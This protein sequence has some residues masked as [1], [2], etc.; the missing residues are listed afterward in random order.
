MSPKTKV[1]A[2]IVGIN[3]Y[4]TSPLHGCVP[5]AQRMLQYLQSRTDIEL[6]EQVLLDHQGTKDNIV[7]GF[8]THLSQ[9]GPEDTVFFYFSGHGA[10]ERADERIWINEL[11]G[12]LE[13]IACYSADS[14]SLMAD[15]ELRFLIHELASGYNGAPPHILTVFDCCHSGDNTRSAAAQQMENVEEVRERR[16]TNV[17][18]QREWKDFLFADRIQPSDFVRSTFKELFPQGPHV[19]IAAAQDKQ[20]ALEIGGAGVFTSTLLQVLKLSGGQIDYTSLHSLLSNYIRFKHKQI[21]QLASQGAPISLLRAGFLNQAVTYEGELYGDTIYNQKKGW[22]LN[23]GQMHGLTE[24]QSVQVIVSEDQPLS[25]P[26]KVAHPSQ[27]ELDIPFEQSRE[28]D[29]SLFYKTKV[30][31]YE[32]YP[33]YLYI[34]GQ[35][36]LQEGR[37]RLEQE[38]KAINAGIE[39]VPSEAKADYVLHLQNGMAYLTE[40]FDPYRPVLS[41]TSLDEKDWIDR[42]VDRIRQLAQW[43]FALRLHNNKVKL[44]KKPP[45]TIE[46]SQR[47]ADEMVPVSTNTGTYDIGEVN[48]EADTEKY[49][50]YLSIKITNNFKRPLYFCMLLLSEDRTCQLSVDTEEDYGLVEKAVME[51]QPGRSYEVFQHYDP[52]IPFK[53][54]QDALRYNKPV[55][56]SW[57]KFLVSTRDD[58]SYQ[59]LIVPLSRSVVDMPK[60][61]VDDWTTQTIEIKLQNPRYNQ[62]LGQEIQSYLNDPEM[63]PFAA[64]LYLAPQ[65]MSSQLGLKPEISILQPEMDGP[66]RAERNFVWDTIVGAANKW[67]SS[68]RLRAFRKRMERYPQRTL[69]VSEG[70]SWFQHP[71]VTETIDHLSLYYNIYSRG[72]AGDEMRGYMMSGDFINAIEDIKREYPDRSLRFFL[73]SGGGNDI[74][75]EQFQ[76]FVLPYAEVSEEPEGE[77]P[78]RFL[79]P[80]FFDEL[81]AVMALYRMVLSRMRTD[82]S[83][84]HIITHGYD[85]VWPKGVEEKGMSWLGTPMSKAGIVREGDRKAIVDYLID[86]FNSRLAEVVDDYADIATHLDLRGTVKQYQWYDEIHPNSEGYQ[87]IALKYVQLIDSKLQERK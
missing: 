10:Q 73:I 49:R 47:K 87:N 20:P 64:G 65:G 7:S 6:H 55:S 39:R 48:W 3:D 76:H 71:T 11:D 66:V 53:I 43:E 25:V 57:L 13:T 51:L 42:M 60:K 28:L 33:L 23:M 32:A 81:E 35:H 12:F 44:L 77:S 34:N 75:G 16:F 82:H 45:L 31:A 59:H 29:K 17:F 2:L 83:D 52:V 37:S 79:S 84:V 14:L 1:Y 15:K 24:G 78:K 46:I 22:L 41:P 61:N 63:A 8:R 27:S 70:D 9:A 50:A 72:A 68:S 86:E 40:A 36:G 54:E 5:D 56:K 80:L 4:P 85:Y 67:A 62:V 69:M 30:S 58:I 38:I 74:L 21:P 26:I 18:P 19:Q